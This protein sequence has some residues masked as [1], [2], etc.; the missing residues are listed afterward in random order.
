MESLHIFDWLGFKIWISIHCDEIWSAVETY[1]SILTSSGW[2]LFKGK[3]P[4]LSDFFTEINDNW[5]TLAHLLT[6]S[7][8]FDVVID[9]TEHGGWIPVWMALILILNLKFFSDTAVTSKITVV[10]EKNFWVHLHPNFLVDW[11]KIE[12]LHWPV[13][14][15]KLMLD[16]FC[17]IHV[18]GREHFLEIYTFNAD[19]HWDLYQ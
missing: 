13:C 14:L 15:W 11:D 9:T 18:Q 1:N 5:L 19:I 10:S 7:Y 4:T 16:F 6:H 3:N 2:S 8:N 12:E 17:T